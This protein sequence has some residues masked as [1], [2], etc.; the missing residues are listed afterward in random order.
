VHEEPC[1]DGVA[2]S[3]ILQSVMTPYEAVYG[4]P[5]FGKG[6]STSDIS[7]A[8]DS[9]LAHR[10]DSGGILDVNVAFDEFLSLQLNKYD[11]DLCDTKRLFLDEIHR[12]KGGVT[13]KVDISDELHQKR[14]VVLWAGLRRVFFHEVEPET[15]DSVMDGSFPS[16]ASPINPRRRIP[17]IPTD[18]NAPALHFFDESDMNDSDDTPMHPGIGDPPAAWTDKGEWFEPSSKGECSN[19]EDNGDDHLPNGEKITRCFPIGEKISQFDTAK[20]FLKELHF[21]RIDYEKRK[22]FLSTKTIRRILACKETIHKYGVFVPRNDREADSSPEAKRWASGRQLEWLRLQEQGTFERNWDWLRLRKFYPDY[23]KRD[24]GHVFYVYDHKHS[25]EHRVRLVFDG[26]RQNPETY[27]DTYAPTARGESVRLFHVYAVEESWEI[28]QFD[29][30][31][32]FL[33]SPIDCILF[34]YPP[35]GFEEFPGQLLRLRLSL[36]GAKQSAALWNRMIDTFLRKMGFSPS[37]IEPCLYRRENA[38]IILFCDDL[39]VAGLPDTVLEIKAALF[40]E[41]QITTSDGTRFLGMDT[42]Y[43]IKQGYLKLHMETYIVATH[44]R[45]RGFDLTRGVPFREIVGCLLWICLGIQILIFSYLYI[46][47]KP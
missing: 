29:L 45:F 11:S 4:M 37:P 17:R 34:V 10:L 16:G 24:V 22:T 46:T 5:C 15:D 25:G 43:N 47:N 7:F 40:R 27:T 26:S 13:S 23:Q 21:P 9:F 8:L 1:P 38:I 14:T 35:K 19:G 44:E 2:D 42:C 12:R 32:A 3:S 39:R 31:Q 33:K 28:A 36:Y 41:F 18:M 30:P 6:D 20:A